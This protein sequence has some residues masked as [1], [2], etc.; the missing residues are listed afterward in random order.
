MRRERECT[1]REQAWVVDFISFRFTWKGS[2]ECE[3]LYMSLMVVEGEEKLDE[4][5][6]AMSLSS[7]KEEVDVGGEEED[8]GEAEEEDV[9]GWDV[10][11]MVLL[12]YLIVGACHGE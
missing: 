12:G 8:S 7:S 1:H 2:W 6:R 5:P 10:F 11:M 3:F 9:V 4:A